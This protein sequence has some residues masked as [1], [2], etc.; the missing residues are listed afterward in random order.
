MGPVFVNEALKFYATDINVHYI[1]NIEGD[2]IFEVLK[3][4][5]PESTVFIIASKTFTTQETIINAK[6]SISTSETKQ[7]LDKENQEKDNSKTIQELDREK[8]EKKF[9]TDEKGTIN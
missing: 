4:I 5:D 9:S 8:L 2:H 3:S 7:V 1:S 6:S